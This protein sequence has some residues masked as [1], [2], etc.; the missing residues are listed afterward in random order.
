MLAAAAV[1]LTAC[2]GASVDDEP[3]EVDRPPWMRGCDQIYYERY[4]LPKLLI[5]SDLPLRGELRNI[6]H[7]MTQAVKLVVKERGFRTGRFS[8]AYVS[9]DDSGSDTGWSRRR[10][11]EHAR[12][13]AHR[14]K[15]I[16]VMLPIDLGCAAIAVPPLAAAR[17]G[18]LAQV[19]VLNAALALPERGAVRVIAPTPA[20]AAADA[21]LIRGLDADS[22][23]VIDDGTAYGRTFA[24][25]FR[26]LAGEVGLRVEAEPERA[27]A[28]LVAG[29]LAPR[30][31]RALRE[32]RRRLPA[33]APIVLAPAF[34]APAQIA[35]EVGAAAEGAYIGV[36]GVAG[37]RLPA[38]GRDFATRFEEALHLPPHPLALYAAEAAELLLDAIAESNGTRA[39]VASALRRSSGPG[40]VSW[41]SFD[42]GGE[43]RVAPVTVYR[44]VD[45]NERLNRIVVPPHE[46]WENAKSA[47]P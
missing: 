26:Q 17:P 13:A 16:G 33:E 20:Q 5:L 27:G 15:V 25:T 22:V 4:G 35:E 34:G 41:I 3:V 12:E 29:S 19:A 28:A 6:T 47:V 42:R 45:G 8:V 9:C 23:A 30:G 31:V 32:A 38:R 37:K 10:C 14:E 43:P 1:L 11:A 18:P 44:I 40:L 21:L 7:Q 36:S 39:S 24:A 2:G 46:L